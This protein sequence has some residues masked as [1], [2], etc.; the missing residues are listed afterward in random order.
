MLWSP[1]RSRGT[2]VIA[3]VCVGA[4]RPWNRIELASEVAVF[5]L[6]LACRDADSVAVAASSRARRPLHW[7]KTELILRPSPALLRSRVEARAGGRAPARAGHVLVSP[8]AVHEVRP[9]A[10]GT[11]AAQKSNSRRKNTNIRA[12]AIQETQI[13]VS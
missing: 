9:D 6:M 10:H 5:L 2:L 1:E 7:I 8:R 13:T 11:S 4:R 3:S 12:M